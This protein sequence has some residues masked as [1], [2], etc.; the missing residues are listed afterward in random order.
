MSKNILLPVRFKRSDK[1]GEKEMKQR[2]R[3]RKT[4]GR[5]REIGTWIEMI[6]NWIANEVAVLFFERLITG[7]ALLNPNLNPKTNVS[8]RFAH[9][10]R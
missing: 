9:E 10:F 7:K 6:E 5:Q 3:R 4:R 1:M 2:G 8:F